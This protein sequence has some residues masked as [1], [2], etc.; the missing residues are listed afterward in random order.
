MARQRRPICLS[1]TVSWCW[2]A[3]RNLFEIRRNCLNGG[4]PIPP[5]AFS[6]SFEKELNKEKWHLPTRNGTLRWVVYDLPYS[7]MEIFR[8]NRG[9]VFFR[10]STFVALA[11]RLLININLL[12]NN[13]LFHQLL[14]T[15]TIS[16]TLNLENLVVY[17][18]TF[19]LLRVARLMIAFPEM[20]IVMTT[21]GNI[22]ERDGFV[23]CRRISSRQASY[24]HL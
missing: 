13:M 14:K 9:T 23:P 10:V 20:R 24:P 11:L 4:R 18:V 15:T 17:F 22:G 16:S 21:F 6:L 12:H 2:S 7:D 8:P 1:A 3:T 5:S 19:R